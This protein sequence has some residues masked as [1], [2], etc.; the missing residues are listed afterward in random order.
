M[1]EL[2]KVITD[3]DISSITSPKLK[4]IFGTIKQIQ[5][6]M[7]DPDL[8]NQEFIRVYDVLGKEFSEFA[9][10]YTHIFTKVVRC[11]DLKTVAAVL[12]YKDKVDRGLMTEA[13]LSEMLSSKYL[14]KHLKDESDAKIKEMSS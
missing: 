14:P 11:E 9:D 12:Y 6:R 10:T 4:N 3:K 2:K 8:V 7:K 5:K 1:A 13:E